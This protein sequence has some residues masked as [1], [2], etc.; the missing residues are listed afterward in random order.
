MNMSKHLSQKQKIDLGSFY[1]PP[2]LVKL[3]NDLINPFLRENSLI[4]DFAAGMGAFLIPHATQRTLGVEIDSYAYEKLSELDNSRCYKANALIEVTREKYGILPS[5]HVVSIG[6]PPYNDVTSQYKKGIKD[7]SYEVD[8]DLYSRDL[9]ISFLRMYD[10]LS[11]DVVCILHPLSYLI[12]ETNFKSL[13]SF[14]E[15]YILSKA[16]I[17]PSTEFLDNS[18]TQFPIVTALYLRDSRGMDFSYI[19]SFKF[20]ILGRDERFSLGSF[21]TTD[22][23]IPKY[24]SPKRALFDLNIFFQ[25]FRDINSLRRNATFL[26]D[27]SASTISI[28]QEDFYKYAYLFCFKELFSPTDMFLYGNLSP[29]IADTVIAIDKRNLFIR[30]A[31]RRSKILQEYLKKHIDECESLLDFYGI[32]DLEISNVEIDELIG[33]FEKLSKL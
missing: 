27:R 25:T 18:K 30:Y 7:Q 11:A 14:R 20:G 29:I 5:D 31:F 3:V 22:G 28:T 4:C 32:N 19:K 24:P 15:N 12:K 8:Q 9:G 21:I 23:F 10:K 2:H 6:N 26:L 16:V 33:Y 17:F 1:T 13:K